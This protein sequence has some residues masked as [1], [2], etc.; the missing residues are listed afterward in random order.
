MSDLDNF[1]FLIL[2]VTNYEEAVAF[3]AHLNG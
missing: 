2:L 1:S 3:F